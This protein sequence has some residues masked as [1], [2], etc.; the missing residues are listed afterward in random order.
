MKTR[1]AILTTV[2]TAAAALVLAAGGTAWAGGGCAHGTAP[3][4]GQ[5]T[6][7]EMVDACFTPTVLHV[8]PGAEVTFVNREG[9]A[10]QVA[11]VGDTWG[12]FDE[13]GLDDEASYTFDA[14]GVY[15]YSCLIHPGMIGAVVAGSG[16][17][18]AGMEPASV[19]GG[20]I[21]GSAAA[22]EAETRTTAARPDDGGATNALM[23]GAGAALVIGGALA[24]ATMR[25]RRTHS[26]VDPTA[27]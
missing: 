20:A 16:E 23:A 12:S 8:D 1:I 2:A 17:G 19:S 5:G 18:D 14:E 9:T 15:L 27:H 25:R 24:A 13:L 6:T 4:D 26:L 3:S 11:G 10:H 7:V 22:D 21:V